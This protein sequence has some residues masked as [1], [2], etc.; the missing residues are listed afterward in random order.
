M[1]D[2]RKDPD[3]PGT[4]ILLALFLMASARLGS[5]NAMETA[6]K[7][8]GC[9]GKTWRRWMG[10]DL[11]SADRLGEVA[12]L[13]DLD[14]LRAVLLEHHRRRKRKK[15]LL[16]LPG[17]L[18]VL[19]LDAHEMWTSYRRTCP[20]AL[21]RQVKCKDEVRTQYYQRYVAAYLMGRTGRVLLDLEM[22]RPGEGE[23]AAAER[24]LQRLLA[25]CPRAF[26]VVAG[27]A[28]YLDPN[29]CRLVLDSKKD[30]IAVLKNE[31]RALIQDF[32]GAVELEGGKAKHFSFNGKNCACHDMEGF[33]TWTQLGHPVRIVRSL[34]TATVRR[35]LT[36]ETEELSSEWLWATSLPKTKAGTRT[37]VQIGHGRWGIENQ[38]FNELVRYWH[39]DHVY[40]LDTNAITVI[41]LLIFLA[42]NLFHVWLDRGLKRD[43]RKKYTAD[44]FA[45][46]LFADFY[47]ELARPG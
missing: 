29:L 38:G 24:L 7:A 36:K 9:S 19:I 43:F 21:S 41:L 13:M 37:V 44:Y 27:D 34:E 30:F 17:G 42:Y 45:R 4:R 25:N 14:D 32:R 8:K 3:I 6:L 15:T 35:Q 39:A 31:N 46:Q 2:R 11:P 1:A 28:L 40:H 18:R 12:A 20:G 47:A 23:I 26:N 10:G 16:P 22:Q 5:L 33:T